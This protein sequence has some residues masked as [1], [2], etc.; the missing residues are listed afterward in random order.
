MNTQ[1]AQQDPVI[2]MD[3]LILQIFKLLMKNKKQILDKLGLTCSQF[4]ILT[5]IHYFS[6][7]K[8]DTIQMDLSEKTGIDPMTTSTILRNLERKELI[9]RRRSMINTR[10]VLVG[11]TPEGSKLLEQATMRIRLSRTEI[12]RNIDKDKLTTQLLKILKKLNN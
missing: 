11:L 4:D 6:T 9:T 12:Y 1:E 5:A 7:I 3:I 8:T 10:T 2:K